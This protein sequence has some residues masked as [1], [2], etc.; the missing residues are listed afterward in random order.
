MP[1]HISHE[2]NAF[3][4]SSRGESFINYPR[5][6]LFIIGPYICRLVTSQTLILGAMTFEFTLWPI[7]IASQLIFLKEL[8]FKAL[9]MI[10]FG[11]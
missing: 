5:F 2:E 7:R 1:F 11:Q 9:N 8:S 3:T 6:T 10:P 4:F